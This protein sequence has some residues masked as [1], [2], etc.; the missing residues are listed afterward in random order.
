[1]KRSFLL[2]MLVVILVGIGS[3]LPIANASSDMNGVW[4]THGYGMLVVI[5]GEQID[6][7]DIGTETCTLLFDT[8]AVKDWG[9]QFSLENNELLIRDSLT[10][11]MVAERLD[12]MPEICTN[13]GTDDPEVNFEAFW[14][15]FNDHYAFFDLHGVDWQAQYDLYRPQV[16]ASTTPDELF[17]ILSEM[18]TPLDDDHITLSNGEEEFTPALPPTWLSSPDELIPALLIMQTVIANNYLKGDVSFDLDTLSFQGDEALIADPMIFY[19]KLSDSVGYI[20]IMSEGGYTDADK[21]VA[22]AEAAMDRIIAEF[23][24]LDTVIIDLS[25]NFGGEDGVALIFASRFA[26]QKRLVCSKQA[27]D[28]SG[29][30]PVR[31]FYVEPG[32]PQQFTRQ[33]ILITSQHTV[34]AGETFVLAMEVLPHV[35]VIGEKTAG[36]YSDMLPR[37]L[38]NGW[39]FSLS[40]E[41]YTAADGQIYEKIGNPPDIEVPLDLAGFES[42][43][44]NLL[45]FALELAAQ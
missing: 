19:G 6:V 5:D 42:G 15:E 23:A 22:V 32:G 39:Q 30:T 17:T 4:L 8:A 10:I 26:D 7:Y 40:N 45:D 31:E 14:N 43:T 20:Y 9:L 1:M 2:S 36:A 33:V 38:P 3:I 35:T 41:V 13:G 11:Y 29:F 12:A 34:S 21:K 37:V 44:D 24:D 27:R 16:T 18:I 28:G 25:G